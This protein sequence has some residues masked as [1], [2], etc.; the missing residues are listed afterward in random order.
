MEVSLQTS[1]GFWERFKS[2]V[3]DWRRMSVVS[4][5][6][7]MLLVLFLVPQITP[8]WQFTVTEVVELL[9]MLFLVSLF[10]ERAVEVIMGAWRGREKQELEAEAGIQRRF[11]TDGKVKEDAERAYEV[12][13]A[14][15]RVF[16][17]LVALFIGLMISALGFRVLQPL[18]DPIAHRNLPGWHKALFTSADT[19]VTGAMIGG[20]SEG[21]HRVLDAFL[22]QFDR[23]RKYTKEKIG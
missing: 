13:K 11:S 14:E 15:F 17:L 2:R 12:Y 4:T 22:L 19:F 9:M 23:W 20:G 5:V 8:F 18:V 3:T 10:V 16:S 21:I 6:V 7:V 1:L